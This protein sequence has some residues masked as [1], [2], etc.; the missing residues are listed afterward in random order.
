M[1]QWGSLINVRTSSGPVQ[2]CIPEF[3]KVSSTQALGSQ[4]PSIE[5]SALSMLM[6][7]QHPL[8]CK[9]CS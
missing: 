5:R 6:L 9:A 2:N 7:L 4:A 1:S 8:L 3:E